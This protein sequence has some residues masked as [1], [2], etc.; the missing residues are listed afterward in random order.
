MAMAGFT[1]AASSAVLKPLD[2][3]EKAGRSASAAASSRKT[4][5]GG[6]LVVAQARAAGAEYLFTNPGSMEVGFFDAIVDEPNLHLIEGLHEG[7]VISMADG[8]HHV[9]GKPAFVN[10]H[11]AAGTA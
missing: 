6:E 4:G 5:T 9:S 3:S 1:A 8:Y 7:I 10:L 11:V 2:A